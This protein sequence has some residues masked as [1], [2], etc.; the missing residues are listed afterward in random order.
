MGDKQKQVQQNEAARKKTATE[1]A[2]PALSPDEALLQQALTGP[3]GQPADLPGQSNSRSL[4]Q[5]QLLQVQRVHGNTAVQRFLAK[6]DEGATPELQ[7]DPGSLQRDDDDAGGS[8]SPG[9]AAQGG[10][11]LGAITNAT[12]STYDVSGAT[13]D[14]IT[15]QLNQLEGHAAMTNSP[16][17]MSGQV[18]PERQEDGSLRVE[19]PWAINDAVVTLPNWTDYGA[20]CEAAQQEWDRFMGRARQHEQQAHVDAALAMVAALPEEDRIVTGADRDELVQ[21][22]QAKQEE[23]AGRIQ[24]MH[25]GC[26]HGASIDAILHPDDGR[27]ET[28][29]EESTE[30]TEAIAESLPNIAGE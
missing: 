24:A 8:E 15:G 12:V 3:A 21:N 1:P 9:E 25:D 20:A 5:A 22:M 19:V 28:E 23:I 2:A 27:C 26:D 11:G 29:G 7:A 13:L 30:G 14:D 18:T 16:L 10:G 17:G 4:R 6:G